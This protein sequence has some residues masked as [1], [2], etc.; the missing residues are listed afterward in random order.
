MDQEKVYINVEL[1][2]ASFSTNERKAKRKSDRR[3]LEISCWIKSSLEKVI[4]GHLFP[5]SEIDIFLQVIQVDGGIAA[6]AINS[7]TLAVINA[8]IAMHDYIVSI[9]MSIYKGIPL[10]DLNGI[11]ESLR[12]PSVTFALTPL[13]SKV[14]LVQS[15][16]RILFADFEKM[17]HLAGPTSS[18]LHKQMNLFVKQH[19]EEL[20][21][22]RG[23][24]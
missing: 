5:N 13:L 12:L 17:L 1:Q 23:T 10:L 18:Q 3:L 19:L 2:L 15:E 16:S 7:A 24:L 14:I 22:K 20:V 6:A 4:M 21:N 11:E 8:G 9:S